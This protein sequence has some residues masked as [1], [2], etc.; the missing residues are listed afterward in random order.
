MEVL[1]KRL[2]PTEQINN[3]VEERREVRQLVSLVVYLW[4]S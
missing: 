3:I 1:Y 2:F 4:P